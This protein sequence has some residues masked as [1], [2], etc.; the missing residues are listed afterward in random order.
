M[1][2]KSVWVIEAGE[3]SDYQVVG[4]FSTREN[5]ELVASAIG[6]GSIAEWDLDPGVDGLRQGHPRFRVLMLR[7]GSVESVEVQEGW[8][9]ET[10]YVWPRSREPI[11]AGKGIPDALNAW[12]WARDEKHAVKIVNEKRAQMIA[13]GEWP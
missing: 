5:A 2:P 10:F 12:V 13:N 8:N 6:Y 3:Y 4:V 7:D 9:A 1:T 11:Y